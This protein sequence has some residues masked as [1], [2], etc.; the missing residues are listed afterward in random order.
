MTSLFVRLTAV[1]LVVAGGAGAASAQDAASGANVFKKCRA[2]HDA[3]PNARNKVGPHLNGIYGRAA[4]AVGDFNY[5]DALK[6][7]GAKKLVWDD[8]T[9]NGYLES[10]TTYLPKN[11]M[12]FAGIKD[13]KQRADLVAYLKT[14]K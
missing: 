6:E 7:A 4:A 8:E 3:G 10:P 1:A 11:K 2:C 13:E 14:F 9:L 5:S 12:A